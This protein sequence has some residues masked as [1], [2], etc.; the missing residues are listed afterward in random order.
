MGFVFCCV[1]LWCVERK[2]EMVGE[3]DVV[4]GSVGGWGVRGVCEGFGMCCCDFGDYRWWDGA[5][6]TRIVVGNGRMKGISV[7]VWVVL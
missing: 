2:L 4:R 6:G 5:D 1:V 3:C 7:V